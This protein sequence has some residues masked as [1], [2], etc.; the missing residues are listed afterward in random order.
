MPQDNDP[1]YHNGE[2]LL[3]AFGCKTREEKLECAVIVLMD[4]L[5]ENH[6]LANEQDLAKELDNPK[7]CCSCADAYRMGHEA[8]KK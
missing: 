6:I 3:A 2:Q 5:N 7:V 4:Q 8:L 1:M